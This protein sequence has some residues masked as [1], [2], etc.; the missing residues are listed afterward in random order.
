MCSR[1]PFFTSACGGCDFFFLYWTK[2]SKNV[3]WEAVI[4]KADE[5]DGASLTS[6]LST[7]SSLIHDFTVLNSFKSGVNML[8]GGHLQR[9][10]C[11]PAQST[12]SSIV[13]PLRSRT[14]PKSFH[15][16]KIHF[17]SQKPLQTKRGP[18][19][20]FFVIFQ[21]K[22]ITVIYGGSK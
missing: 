17:H 19:F 18:A 15:K 2:P 20:S 16:L 22:S 5:L 6:A 9:L 3:G 14:R 7:S 21:T 1:M 13:I 11:K 4:Q 8:V 12:Q 10:L